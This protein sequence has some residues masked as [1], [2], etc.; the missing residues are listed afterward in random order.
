MWATRR[1]A[2]G[3]VTSTIDVPSFRPVS[4]NRRPSGEVYP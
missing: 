1:G 2:R 4:A 3:S